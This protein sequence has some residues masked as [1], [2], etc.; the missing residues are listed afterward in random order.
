MQDKKFITISGNIG[1]GKST[2]TKKL[3]EHYKFKPYLEQDVK[4]PYLEDF[5]KNMKRWAFHSQMFFLSKRLE[6]HYQLVVDKDSVVEDRS[7][8]ENAEVFARY[9]YQRGFISKREWKTYQRVYQTC[10]N[11]LPAPDLI[12]YLRASTET[13]LR[14]LKSS[15]RKIEKNINK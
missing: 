4:N 15:G 7:I 1:I 13:I 12:V 9:C 14:R 3:A 11:I 8:Y 2:L 10:K 6:D 5:Y